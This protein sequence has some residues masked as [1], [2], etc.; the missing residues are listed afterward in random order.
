MNAGCE[1]LEIT[2][3]GTHVTTSQIGNVRH[4]IGTV[5]LIRHSTLLGYQAEKARLPQSLNVQ[6]SQTKAH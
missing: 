4:W 1:F 2:V 6:S 3:F 5:R